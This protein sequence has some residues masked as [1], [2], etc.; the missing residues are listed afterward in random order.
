MS[1]L[2]E[3]T[4]PLQNSVL[5]IIIKN[6]SNHTDVHHLR[7]NISQP[8]FPIR[9]TMNNLIQISR[10]G[11][12]LLSLLIFGYPHRLLWEGVLFRQPLRAY[13]KNSITFT[14]KDVCK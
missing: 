1:Y 3:S 5:L 4:W 14:V 7:L 6:D 11:N 8:S 9:F 13:Q 2:N 12:Y 10:N